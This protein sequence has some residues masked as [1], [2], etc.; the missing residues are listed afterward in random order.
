MAT[1]NTK[2]ENLSQAF[3]EIAESMV[4]IADITEGSQSITVDEIQRLRTAFDTIRRLAQHTGYIAD[5][6]AKE[7]GSAQWRGDADDWL[8]PDLV[9]GSGGPS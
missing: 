9:K 8:I 7:L 3:F 2:N 5:R 6:M 4:C 1:G